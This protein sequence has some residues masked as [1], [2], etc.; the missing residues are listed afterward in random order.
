MSKEAVAVAL[1]A[2]VCVAFAATK[3]VPSSI[4]EQVGSGQEWAEAP[5]EQAGSELIGVPE[6]ELLDR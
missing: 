4:R 2:I 3:F 6:G 1:I 5:Q